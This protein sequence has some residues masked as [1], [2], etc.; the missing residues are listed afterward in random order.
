MAWASHIGYCLVVT[1]TM[2]WIMTFHSVGN[3]TSSQLTFTPS[4]FRGVGWNHQPGYVGV[5]QTL[6]PP[7]NPVLSP[8]SPPRW[9]NGLATL[10]LPC[11]GGRRL[12]R[13][14]PCCRRVRISCRISWGYDG[15]IWKRSFRLDQ[16]RQPDDKEWD[17]GVAYFSETQTLN[18][19]FWTA[20]KMAKTCF[21]DQAKE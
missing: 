18:T 8:G 3:G 13:T 20:N 14:G 16:R 17:C 19:S 2:E 6:D 5:F 4:F 10:P 15:D 21:P 1:G 9:W 11:A 7:K 12:C